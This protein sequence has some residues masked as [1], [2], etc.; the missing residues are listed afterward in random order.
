MTASA[1]LLLQ[2]ATFI[3]PEKN[4]TMKEIKEMKSCDQS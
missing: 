2:K 4:Q 1:K 3:H